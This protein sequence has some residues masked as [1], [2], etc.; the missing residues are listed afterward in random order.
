MLAYQRGKKI[1]V[2]ANEP[3]DFRPTRAA[4][5]IRPY[6][7][8][9]PETRLPESLHARVPVRSAPNR[10]GKHRRRGVQFIAK[11]PASHLGI[12]A[13]LRVLP[14]SQFRL[15]TLI[16]V[17]LLAGVALGTERAWRRR[18]EYLNRAADH[19][20]AEAKLSA[21]SRALA[22]ELARL[23]P[24]LLRGPCGN[25]RRYAEA[26]DG[27]MTTDAERAAEH[28]RL[29]ERYLQAASRPWEPGPGL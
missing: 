20:A 14:A 6:Q 5:R 11:H 22:A 26:L 15:R 25:P 10:R 1:S 16:L 8:G 3:V 4:S 9:S 18:R 19:A 24:W 28:G 21:K 2:V 13:M 12:M 7:N 23:S 17:V 27:V 29:K